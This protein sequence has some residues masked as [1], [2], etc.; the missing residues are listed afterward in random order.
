MFGGSQ[1]MKRY[2][3]YTRPFHLGKYELYSVIQQL[4]L[5]KPIDVFLDSLFIIRQPQKNTPFDDTFN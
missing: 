1:A 4:N 5:S 3:K 2:L